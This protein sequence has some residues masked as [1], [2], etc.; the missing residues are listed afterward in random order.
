MAL[1]EG[2][3]VLQVESFHLPT[4]GCIDPKGKY[5]ICVVERVDPSCYDIIAGV[6]IR[7]AASNGDAR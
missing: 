2:S 3:V 1:V 5:L 6:T 7:F 4:K